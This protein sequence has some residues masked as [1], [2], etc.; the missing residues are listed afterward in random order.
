VPSPCDPPKF[1]EQDWSQFDFSRWHLDGL[2]LDSVA[3]AIADLTQR[4]TN[5][6]EWQDN[7]KAT[8]ADLQD[9]MLNV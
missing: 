8:V 6:P 2:Q 7:V 4:L 5:S 9:V 3:Q 1:D